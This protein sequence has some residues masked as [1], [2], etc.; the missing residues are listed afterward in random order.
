[1]SDDTIPREISD[2]Q[3]SEDAITVAPPAQNQPSA[4]RSPTRASPAKRRTVQTRTWCNCD[5][6]VEEDTTVVCNGPHHAQSRYYHV[7]CIPE[8]LEADTEW[9]C[10]HCI[11]KTAE[12]YSQGSSQGDAALWSFKAGRDTRQSANAGDS[13]D[14][15][16]DATPGSASDFTSADVEA[17]N[18]YWSHLE[19]GYESF[20][21]A[22][23]QDA[24]L[25]SAAKDLPN[26]E[27]FSTICEQILAS[28]SDPILRSVCGSGLK[29]RKL[30]DIRL[31]KF[32]NRNFRK[33]LSRPCIY[34]FEFV[35]EEGLGPSITKMRRLIEL[36]WQ[37]VKPETQEDMDLAIDVD[38]VKGRLSLD[39]R[40]DSANGWRRY[41][42]GSENTRQR[43]T[44]LL[45]ELTNQLD[46]LDISDTDKVPFLIRDIG[47]TDNAERR[48]KEQH[49]LHNSSN[50]LM[51]LLEAISL[52]DK[53]LKRKYSFEA[54]VIFLCYHYTHACWGEIIFS[55]LAQSYV[56]GGKGVNG[57]Q[58]GLNITSNNR[59]TVQDWQ[60]WASETFTESPLIPNLKAERERRRARRQEHQQVLSEIAQLER[61]E[62]QTEA[63]EIQRVIDSEQDA[64][65]AYRALGPLGLI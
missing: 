21:R 44:A 37:Y 34:M 47:Y 2:S 41:I 5:G 11:S 19:L 43:I 50:K 53:L 15:E 26:F 63:N 52:S 23:W 24:T 55:L 60:K 57:K 38:E 27:V 59:W 17:N 16:D 7:E 61:A 56:D 36:A 3:E 64:S 39:E 48:I 30:V 14:E 42:D 25:H 35:D 13:E 62:R 9:R 32:L 6:D 28:V 18:P 1:M 40:T 46:A 12:T 49:A 20:A 31:Q 29:K 51:N 54:D 58:A 65:D 10:P 8:K 33:G 22:L 45:T 4:L